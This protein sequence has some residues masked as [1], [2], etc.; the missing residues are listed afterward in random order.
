MKKN[1][2]LLILLF[3]TTE[4]IYSQTSSPSLQWSKTIRGQYSSPF[5][6]VVKSTKDN[7]G[8]IYVLCQD[9]INIYVVKYDASGAIADVMIYNGTANGTEYAYDIKL[10]NDGNIII[11]ASVFYAS[12]NCPAIIK[13]N[14]SGDLLWDKLITGAYPASNH[15]RSI[16]IDV[17]NNI[18]FC[19]SINDSLLAGKVSSTG[20]TLW[21][22]T[23]SPNSNYST[24]VAYMIAADDNGI[25]YLSG[26]AV[27]QNGNSDL[28]VA[29][30]STGGA[31]QWYKTINGF[32]NEN[33]EA[34]FI[35]VDNNYNCY[36]AGLLADTSATNKTACVIKYN[37]AGGQQWAKKLHQAG[38]FKQE[39]VSVQ[40]FHL[41]N[42]G[43]SYIALKEDR[44]NYTSLNTK[45]IKL[46][47]LGTLNWTKL[48]EG[49]GLD[50]IPY[51]LSTDNFGNVYACGTEALPVGADVFVLKYN[52]SG[53]AIFSNTYEYSASS[54]ETPKTLTIDN[55]GNVY[56]ATTFN[57]SMDSKQDVGLVKFNNAG[58]LQYESL[59]NAP[60]SSI[61]QSTKLILENDFTYAL[62]T[63]QNDGSSHDI[64]ISN[65]DTHGFVQWQN[66]VDH[67][68]GSNYSKDMAKFQSN[69]FVLGTEN[70][71]GG[72]VIIKYDSIGSLEWMDTIHQSTFSRVAVL[73]N[74]N[75]VFAGSAIY[76]FSEPDFRLAIYNSA[77]GNSIFQNSP[78]QVADYNSDVSVLKVD[79]NDNIYAFGY[80]TFFGVS[81]SYKK[82]Q[83]QKFN[84]AGALQWTTHLTGIDSTDFSYSTAKNIFIDNSF[85][86]YVIANAM[87]LST[88]SSKTIITKYDSNG[89]QIWRQE[90]ALSSTNENL[91]SALM[92]NDGNI[93]TL[94]AQSNGQPIVVRK[95]DP[96]N[97]AEIWVQTPSVYPYT[98]AYDGILAM[99][100]A[101]NIFITSAA[102]INGS[103]HFDQLILLCK[104]DSTGN[105][106]WKT[107][108]NGAYVGNDY[109]NDIKVSDDGRIYLL[110][111]AVMSN[112]GNVPDITLLKFCDIPDPVIYSSGPINNLCPLSSVDLIASGGVSYLWNDGSTTSTTLSVDTTG[113]F[114]SSVFLSDGCF[115][116]TDTLHVNLKTAPSTPEICLVTVDSLSTHNIIVWDKT[117]ITGASAFK[118]YR[119]DVTNVYTLIA[120][121]PYD[122]LSEYHDLAANPNTTTKRY[123]LSAID[124]CG[125]ESG[126]SNYH[127]TIYIVN[128]GLGQYTWNPLYTIENSGNPVDNYVLMRDDN[129]NGNWALITTTA[130]TQNTLVDPNYASFPNASYRV[131]TLWNRNCLSTRGAI[132]TSR[133]NIKSPTSLI[134]INSL[135]GNMEITTFP[136]PFT[137]SLNFESAIYMDKV[138]IELYNSIGQLVYKG[139]HSGNKIN[140]QLPELANGLYHY[141][142]KGESFTKQGVLSKTD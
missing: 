10:D 139:N 101:N 123:K 122:S 119:E 91:G 42:Q 72:S 92:A 117:A 17:N 59:Y 112:Y 30:F 66:V 34:T 26:K 134:G 88:N 85:N 32:M 128:S 8:N 13:F 124:S 106:I 56:L 3:L 63:I 79:Q 28:L 64:A 5:E 129:S 36:V 25:S 131:E 71:S 93:Y 7:L 80:T 54:Y 87:T 120:T 116:N 142:I 57:F 22:Q 6:E 67:E 12:Y 84:S 58:A 94:S 75:P 95:I 20:N 82:L 21:Q 121:V 103:L 137:S 138:S 50:Q 125:Q 86:A 73:S 31:I 96:A 70:T 45:I 89:N 44:E 33:D 60:I 100:S 77:T 76:G 110:A 90:Y 1:L 81:P 39:S 130:G 52:P 11:G 104:L 108:F 29:K 132:N 78:A 4:M 24:G 102:F 49:N 111:S 61:S 35:K 43:N 114:F 2:Y 37:A 135:E 109:P 53:T 62:G 68:S 23:F 133:S 113:D 99:D 55:S 140:I 126:M 40:D 105:L 47:N 51:S 16:A 127:N 38:I 48:H 97:G 15:V 18:H 19:G 27:N 141:T 41:D 65:F 118:I 98:L 83:L 9:Y 107:T 69:L 74:G 136:N 14:P 115:K 46:S